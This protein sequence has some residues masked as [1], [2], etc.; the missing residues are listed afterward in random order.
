V[1]LFDAINALFTKEEI[2]TPPSDFM[3]HRFLSSQPQYAEVA[4]ELHTFCRDR[5]RLWKIWQCAL[6]KKAKAPFLPYPAPKKKTSTTI[7]EKY[8]ELN[9]VSLSVAEEE[10]GLLELMGMTEEL[11][12]DMGI[13]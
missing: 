10:V 12:S 13:E 4:S 8:S 1:D 2:N 3:L 7:I 11:K 5:A 9:N 6:P